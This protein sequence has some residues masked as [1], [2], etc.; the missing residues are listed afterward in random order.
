MH[1]HRLSVKK[2]MEQ[3]EQEL[4]SNPKITKR[5]AQEIIDKM[6]KAQDDETK[7]NQ[8]MRHPFERFLDQMYEIEQNGEGSINDNDISPTPSP[9]N[10]KS[11][12]LRPLSAHHKM[13]SE[14]KEIYFWPETE[15][16]NSGEASATEQAMQLL[17]I[18]LDNHDDS[19][20]AESKPGLRPQKSN[21]SLSLLNVGSINNLSD[22]SRL[23]SISTLGPSPSVLEMKLSQNSG[24]ESDMN[25]SRN[26]DNE[27]KVEWKPTKPTQEILAQFE[28]QTNNNLLL[29]EI[30]R[31][32]NV[33]NIYKEQTKSYESELEQLNQTINTKEEQTETLRSTNIML[34]QRNKELQEQTKRLQLDNDRLQRIVHE[35][36]IMDDDSMSQNQHQCHQWLL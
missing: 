7:E 1:Q 11:Q 23:N 9:K 12:Q 16:E 13:K 4:M 15:N 19:T 26:I 17:E 6:R 33:V 20:S 36:P 25:T 18:V 30:Q 2:Q 21:S 28:L 27:D 24:D 34:T 29:K 5:K 22:K 14:S 10:Q 8:C 35:Y 3:K 31:L 32:R